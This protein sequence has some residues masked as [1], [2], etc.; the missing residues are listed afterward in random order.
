[1]QYYIDNYLF[2]A[3]KYTFTWANEPATSICPNLDGALLRIRL[4]NIDGALL[5]V[6]NIL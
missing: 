5:E 4:Q 2:H 1:M 6:H 3:H